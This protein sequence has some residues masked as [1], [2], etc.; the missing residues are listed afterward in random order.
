MKPTWRM[1]A[2][3][4][5][6]YVCFW[7]T[8]FAGDWFL[9]IPYW[10]Q[11]RPN[12]TTD[13]AISSTRWLPTTESLFTAAA[14]V[15]LLPAMIVGAM[16]LAKRRAIDPLE[17]WWKREDAQRT[18]VVLA[19]TSAVFVA[20]F[21][22]YAVLRKAELL[23]DERSYLFQA[24]L[25]AQG[26]LSLP[27]PPPALVNPMI[28]RQPVWTSVYPPGNA[29]VLT[30]GA[31]LGFA[32]ATP[33]VLAGIVV[34]AIWSFSRDTFGP[35]HGAL[36]ALFAGASPFVWCVH[37]TAM[38]FPTSTTALAVFLAATA[39]SERTNKL[40]WSVVAGLAVGLAFITRPY[41]AA[42]FATPYA[43][44]LLREVRARPKPL[45][46]CFVGFAALAWIIPVHNTLVMGHWKSF[47]WDAPGVPAFRL[48]F[49]HALWFGELVHSPW[50]AIGNLVAV[51]Q[52]T[53]LWLLGWPASLLLVIAGALRKQPTRG[54]RLLRWTIASYVGFY[55]LVPFTGTWDVGPTYY[56]ALVPALVPLAVRGV[57]ALRERATALD[58]SGT[59]T[60]ALGWM[61]VLG[62]VV[63][64][65]TQFPLRAIRLTSLASQILEPWEVIEESD[66]GPA[67]VIVPP[68]EQRKAPGWAH[69]HPFVLHTRKGD[70]VDLVSVASPQQLAEALAYLGDKPVYVLTLDQDTY[71]ETGRRHF[72]LQ[73]YQPPK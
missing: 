15:F 28:L 55:L 14:L 31:L 39:R 13:L 17:A 42:A 45:V 61:V 71:R 26:K 5:A 20:M 34:L 1:A 66:I 64:V 29:L 53:D 60:R 32:R 40:V 8:A 18:V 47:P 58:A 16:Y 62:I 43:I 63:A 41:E 36:A 37:G 30:P 11:G 9:D 59:A 65:T 57:S 10:Y 46:A 27:T 54:D 22:A 6:L 35:K 23:D 50:Q 70:R 68:I 44:R 4:L 3:A 56:Y 2:I 48:G 52:R 73:P 7:A 72:T 51:V 38:S 67:I 12:W 33:P 25:F 19:V 24:N 49:G 69:G 21:V